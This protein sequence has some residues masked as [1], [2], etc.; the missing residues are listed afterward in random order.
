[1]VISGI[2]LYLGLLTS[3]NFVAPCPAQHCDP[4][5]EQN[6]LIIVNANGPTVGTMINSYNSRSILAGYTWSVV[7]FDFS[8]VGAT[9]YKDTPTPNIG[10]VVIYPSVAYNLHIT[11]GFR[12]TA[13]TTGLV[14]SAGISYK[15]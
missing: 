10:G 9:G 8:I 14:N 13:L 5:N 7:D 3:H 6:Q 2:T 15:F 11:H 1:L 4:L 12:L